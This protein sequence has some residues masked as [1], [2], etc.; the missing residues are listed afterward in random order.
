M[1]GVSEVAIKQIGNVIGGEVVAG[2]A[3]D[4]VEVVNPSSEEVLGSFAASTES[5]VAG[6]AECGPGG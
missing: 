5:D 2:S 6:A 4:I 3:D 1:R